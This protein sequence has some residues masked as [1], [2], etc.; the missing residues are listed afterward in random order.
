MLSRRPGF[1]L[2][3]VSLD[4]MHPLQGRLGTEYMV[5]LL[6]NWLE[7]GV[8]SLHRGDRAG[9]GV[10]EEERRRR[11]EASRLG[12]A[13]TDAGDHHTPRLPEPLHPQNRLPAPDGVCYSFGER[14]KARSAISQRMRNL[15][16][17]TAQCRG[18]YHGD[19]D[20]QTLNHTVCPK[21]SA[22]PSASP[23]F[24]YCHRALLP[25]RALSGKGVGGKKEAKVSPG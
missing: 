7:R 15:D 24:S 12:G 1:S 14:R 25:H 19:G 23:G 22:R 4:C 5:D 11:V 16:W 8:S 9:G 21:S 13:S 20:C 10:H 6:A 17:S 18:G 3:D 2:R